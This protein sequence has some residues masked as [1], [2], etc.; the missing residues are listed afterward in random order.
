MKFNGSIFI[1]IIYVKIFFKGTIENIPKPSEV[2]G[3][4]VP[5]NR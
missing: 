4:M 1:P 2:N 3:M 5:Q